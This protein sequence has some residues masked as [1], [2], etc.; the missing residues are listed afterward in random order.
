MRHRRTRRFEPRFL[1]NQELPAPH[2]GVD[3]GRG[4]L[5]CVAA[6]A[7]LLSSDEQRSGCGAGPEH[8]QARVGRVQRERGEWHASDRECVSGGC[9]ER[10]GSVGR[11]SCHGCS[12]FS[13]PGRE[14]SIGVAGPR[15]VHVRCRF[16]RTASGAQSGCNARLGRWR[17]RRRASLVRHAASSSQVEWLDRAWIGG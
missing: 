11:C 15:E 3:K 10:L 6:P 8:D 1:A 7:R 16:V 9:R 17:R 12:G 14:S 13:E 4:E 5:H 2:G